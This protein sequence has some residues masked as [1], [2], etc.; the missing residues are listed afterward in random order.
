MWTTLENTFLIQWYHWSN[1]SQHIIIII[2]IVIIIVI[3]TLKILLCCDLYLH[4]CSCVLRNNTE[5]TSSMHWHWFQ[6]NFPLSRTYA[7]QFLQCTAKVL[8]YDLNFV[9]NENDRCCHTLDTF[10][11]TLASIS[12]Q[13]IIANMVRSGYTVSHY[14]KWCESTECYS[15]LV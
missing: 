1:Q 11:Y 6:M 5:E 10:C 12:S 4:V 8:V 15:K 2:I 7:L 14:Y 13:N 3:W 9:T